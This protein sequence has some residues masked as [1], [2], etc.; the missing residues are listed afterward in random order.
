MRKLK[1][2]FIP[3]ILWFIISTVL[4]TL[5]GSALPNASWLNAIHFD[6][7]VHVGMFCLLVLT[8]CFAMLKRINDPGHLK[9]A[10]TWILIIWILYGAGMEFVQLYFV[11]NRTF[12]LTDIA[13][14]AVGGAAGWLY[15][16]RLFIK[17]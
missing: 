10:F 7:F 12:D 9:K 5:P 1:P 17:K 11:S 3:G 16:L 14:D 4:L 2:S 15:S 8:W 13:A 6:K